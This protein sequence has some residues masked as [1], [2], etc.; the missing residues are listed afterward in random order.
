MRNPISLRSTLGPL[1]LCLLS[2]GAHAAPDA[3]A[4]PGDAGAKLIGP[5]QVAW[6]DMTKEQK[7]RFM[8]VAITPKMK[9]TFQKFDADTFK[10][11]NCSTC[12]GKD[13]KAKEFKMPNPDIA[14]L[15]NT[16]EA[17]QAMMKKKPTW[18]KW[19]KFMAEQ[20]EPQMAGLLGLHPFNP[21][22]PDPNDFGCVR[23]HTLKKM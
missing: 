19:T 10:Q 9:E 22:A 13:A 4:H 12:H 1:V 21:K 3:G 20:V 6:K 2:T 14:P 16:P 17:F 8:K 23:C 11:F 18:P 15:P 7:G 5:P